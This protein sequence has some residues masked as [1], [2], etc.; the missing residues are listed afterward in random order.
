MRSHNPLGV[1]LKISPESLQP[2]SASPPP[3][4]KHCQIC[5]CTMAALSLITNPKL[6][7]VQHLHSLKYPC[8]ITAAVALTV[9]KGMIPP[10]TNEGGKKKKDS[11]GELLSSC[12]LSGK[13]Q[14]PNCNLFFI[15]CV[16]IFYLKNCLCTTYVPGAPEGQSRVSDTL[17]LIV[18]C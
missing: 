13:E 18:G 5:F 3:H 10:K 14:V 4:L 12:P 1:V 15:L 17:R 2:P 16:C 11:C 9:K 7:S 8:I 6:F